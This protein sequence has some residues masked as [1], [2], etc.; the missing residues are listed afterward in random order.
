MKAY[1]L[2]TGILIHSDE[3][4]YHL[5]QTDWNSFI[6]QDSLYEKVSCIIRQAQPITDAPQRLAGQ[7]LPPVG[8]HQEVWASGVTYQRSKEARMEEAKEAGGGDFY[9][10]V[11]DAPR[12]ELFFKSPSYRV[13]GPGKQVRI[14]QDSTWDVPEPELTL[15]ITSS[16]K[17][18]GYTV[19]NDMSSRSIEGENPLYLPQ[20][21]TYDGSCAIGPCVYITPR[22]L[23]R[24]TPIRLSIERAGSQVFDKTITL[25]SMKR[26]E[27]ELVK[28]LFAECSFPYGCLLM[29]GT[30]I[31]PDHPFTLQ[32]GDVIKISIE[33]IGVLENTVA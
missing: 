7:I 18:I 19:G 24:E 29:T 25:Q 28:Y 17:V 33:P 12:P 6:N 11:Y 15:V 10:R 23:A 31:V 16:G 32:S 2:I 9:D 13:V 20:A 3:T 21:K 5:D 22:P 14:R 8:E 30:G 26:T 4:F 1:R 27:E